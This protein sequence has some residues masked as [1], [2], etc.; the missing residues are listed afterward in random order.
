MVSL[1]N[2]LNNG[3]RPSRPIRS[4]PHWTTEVLDGDVYYQD[5]EPPEI[6]FYYQSIFD[7]ETPA[8]ADGWSELEFIADHWHREHQAFQEESRRWL[9]FRDIRDKRREQ[10]L[11]GSTKDG[12]LQRH[13]THKSY[14]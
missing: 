3:G 6:L 14:S 11:A 2:L 1:P 7:S 13:T 12:M 8:P 4:N 10:R 5:A 9:D